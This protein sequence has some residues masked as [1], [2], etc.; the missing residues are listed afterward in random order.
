MPL[1]YLVCPIKHCFKPCFG[2]PMKLCLKPLSM[3][4]ADCGVL[5]RVDQRHPP[6]ETIPSVHSNSLPPAFQHPP[7]AAPRHCILKWT[8]TV[9]DN[10]G[11]DSIQRTWLPTPTRRP[12]IPQQEPSNH[13]P[14]R[15]GTLKIDQRK[16]LPVSS[17]PK[18]STDEKTLVAISK[19]VCISR[20]IAQCFHPLWRATQS[21]TTSTN[22]LVFR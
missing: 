15:I 20:I 18:C 11:V 17:V 14:K 12:G 5:R 3:R 22:T 21:L 2:R 10:A 9:V 1:D 4:T 13:G 6:E 7:P 8:S 19:H 16:S